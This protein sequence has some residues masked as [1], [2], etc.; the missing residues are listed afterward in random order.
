MLFNRPFEEVHAE[1]QQ[2]LSDFLRSEN[3][4]ENIIASVISSGY[5]TV[6]GYSESIFDSFYGNAW[7]GV[8][9]FSKKNFIEQIKSGNPLFRK[10]PEV[11]YISRIDDIQDILLSDERSTFYL[12]N[13]FLSFR[14]QTK[15]YTIQRAFPNLSM[16]NRDRNERLIIPGVWRKYYPDFNKRRLDGEFYNFFTTIL[17]DDL[18]YHGI[19]DYKTLGDRN[20]EKYGIHTMSDLEDFPEWENQEYYR[21]WQDFKVAGSFNNHLAVVCQHYG[22]ETTGLDVS[23]D[24]KT[25]GFFAT[26]RF[27]YKNNGKATF[28]PVADDKHEGVIYCFYFRAPTLTATR[29]IITSLAS[30][31]HM[32]PTRPIR[33]QCAMPFFLYDK[34]NEAAVNLYKVFYLKKDFNP[35]SIASKEYLFPG[36]D[37]DDFYKAL[38][39]VKKSRKDKFFDSFVEYEF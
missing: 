1:D 23:F 11:H 38:L 27:E 3:I 39:D 8:S 9:S 18:I 35:T 17:A 25:A 30:F 29:D 4:E 20:Y 28:Y 24:F 37:E 7:G 33:Q 34:F 10:D 14:G 22:L 31:D 12:N 15:E 5:Y 2:A 36:E 6:P 21:R 32:K 13:G 16:A 26:N 19:P